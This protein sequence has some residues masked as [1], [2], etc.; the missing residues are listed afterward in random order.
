VRT[1]D[2]AMVLDALRMT[3]VY[4]IRE[5]NHQILYYNKRVRE[6]A[7]NIKEGM[8]CH[9]LFKGTCAN[10]PLH[11]IGDKE[12]ARSII[13]GGPFGKAVEIVATRILWEDTTPAF[14]IAVTPYAEVAEYVYH[15]VLRGNLSTDAYD[16]IKADEEE[17][18][19]L[20]EYMATLSEWLDNVAL[21]G[22]V[23]E[24]DI[25]RYRKFMQI[26]RLKKELKNGAQ[27]LSCIYRRRVR[28]RFKWHTLEI[29]PDYDYTDDNQ[30]VMIYVKDVH[31]LFREGLQRE[32]T[33][34]RNQE[35]INTLS[36]V[37]F[38]V[39]LVDL[40]NGSVSIAR[41]T[42]LVKRNMDMEN[43]VWDDVFG[44]KGFEYIAP[45]DQAEFKNK[46]GLSSM[47]Q[48]HKDGE[49]KRTLLCRA[50]L[51]GEWRYVSIT[52]FFKS[53]SVNGGYVILTFQD[54]DERTKRNMVRTQNDRR[55]AAIIKSRYSIL[56]T[57]DLETGKCE[58]TYLE[59]GNPDRRLEGDYSYYIQKALD[60]VVVERD[61]ES[62]KEAL[63]LDNLRK[64][65]EGVED[66]KEEL[67]Q[68]QLKKEPAMW[69]EEQILYIR[70][71]EKTVVNI[72][73]RDITVEKQIE[74]EAHKE[75]QEK[76]SIINSLSGMFFA[77]YYIDF[78]HGTFKPVT[79]K[80]EVG[81]VLGKERS[82]TQGIHIYAENFVHSDDREEYLK[83]LNYKN[84]RNVLSIEHPLTA[85]E[86][87]MVPEKREQRTW[88]R[89][90][91]V[92]A[93]TASDGT[94]KRALYVTQDVTESKLKEER[95]QQALREACDSANQ[96]NAAKSEF[97]SRMSHDI[98]T[99]MNA[100][101]GMTAIAG[102]YLDD[103]EHVAD[104]LSK[105]TVSSKHL[106]SL[107]N[108]VLDM[109]KIESGKIDLAEE[110]INLSDLIGNLVTMTRPSIQQ[111][112]QNLDVRIANIE[113]E[114]VIG[115]SLRLQQIFMNILSNAVKYTPEGGK[116][117]LE[118]NEK[119]A[120]SYSYGCY[121]FIF[122]DNGI[123]MSKEFQEKLFEP[124][125]RA[126][127]SLVSKI[128]GTGLG[129]TIARNIARRMNG[130]ITVKSEEGKGTQFVVTLS[131]RFSNVVMPDTE[132]FMDLPVLVA[133]DDETACEATCLI[134][135][136]IGMKGEYVLGGR[137]AVERVWERHQ[138]AQDYFAVILDWK[139]PD[140]DGVATAQEIRKKVGPDVPIIILS[141]YDW[142]DV[143]EEARSAGVN[144]FISKPL[145]KSRLV[146]LFNQ[147][148]DKENGQEQQKKDILK[149]VELVGKRILLVEDNELNREIAEEIIGQTGVTVE[150][151]EN[152]REAVEQFERVDEH[153]YDMIL[154]DIQ[155]PIMNGYEAA[156]A[157]RKLPRE[158]AAQI[159]IIA[160]TANAFAEDIQRSKASGMNEHLTKPLDIEQL[161]KCLQKWMSYT[162][163]RKD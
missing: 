100:I 138:A 149:E 91:V 77:I 25:K 74:E 43:F 151:V 83:H 30:K 79:Q 33:S 68:Y 132:K 96:A 8:I 94:P 42:D 97:M 155:M 70:Q 60:E 107:I 104:C 37:N 50:L 16:I 144:G 28:D 160:M 82:Y 105:I 59:P 99:P 26:E 53:S 1:K 69:V 27:M 56:N 93:E 85:F 65:A 126:E 32:E 146:Y 11:F 21:R 48:A 92:L 153:Y 114:H 4:V 139:M 158:D 102:R 142:S 127:N 88:I 72:L 2:Y 19:D 41:A 119:P 143:E 36:E 120:H 39:Y 115:D 145:F 67:Y 6:V 121:E 61:K 31:D 98:R 40:Q 23:Y 66:F 152:G 49:A 7:P 55:M 5:D 62:F 20:R 117:E 73:G 110:E 131:F 124:F 71:G 84:L 156:I 44:G 108:E 64:K 45:E 150:S 147:I 3:G 12:E 134:L 95:E 81:N 18:Q 101:I 123:G 10:C 159:P 157:I 113:H 112:K 52:A 14:M 87:R 17:L 63:L 116:I 46:F 76:A 29:V 22:Y 54:V 128:E 129:M 136:N 89:V 38:A 122:R 75:A 57:V 161:M 133:D 24:E 106:L 51:K 130:D 111:K 154:M 140:M 9:E 78:E 135:E 80:E 118:I 90:T 35:I 47:R 34:I 58:R 109:S 137:E 86:Y 141:A 13:Y 15:K 163:G 125:S 162:G 103:K 148:M